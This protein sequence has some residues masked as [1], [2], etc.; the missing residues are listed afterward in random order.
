MN[1]CNTITVFGVIGW[2]GIS[3]YTILF[4][5]ILSYTV[6]NALKGGLFSKRKYHV[7]SIILI[8]T[9]TFGVYFS[10]QI[11]NQQTIC[12][13]K[14]STISPY[15]RS[16]ASACL[17]L[18]ALIS[19]Y[20]FKN[21]IPKNSFFQQQSIYKYYYIYIFFVVSLQIMS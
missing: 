8:I 11:D 19:I 5:I 18:I 3:I 15:L 1:F 2:I 4:C 16:F 20:R 21:G 14:Y 17:I 12:M 13:V 9:A 6:R 7:I 10:N